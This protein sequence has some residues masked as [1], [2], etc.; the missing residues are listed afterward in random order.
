MSKRD[1][2]QKC[3]LEEITE[4][5]FDSFLSPSLSIKVNE[6]TFA[7]I[8]KHNNVE[9]PETQ[10]H[11]IKFYSIINNNIVF[12]GQYNF[13][14]KIIKKSDFVEIKVENENLII[15]TKDYLIVEKIIINIEGQYSFKNV[16]LKRLSEA[17]FKILNNGKFVSFHNNNLKI[18]HYSESTKDI[19][20]L[21]NRNYDKALERLSNEWEKKDES[22]IEENN[23]EENNSEENE[24]ENSLADIIEIKE[25]NLI[26]ISFS[27]CK[28]DYGIDIDYTKN[29]YLISIIDTKN[30]QIIANLINLIEA[31]KLFYFGNEE[32]FSFGLRK[33][34]KL[35]LKVFQKKLILNENYIQSCYHYY[36][37]NVIPFLNENILVSFGYFRFGYYHNRDE[38]KHWCIFDIKNNRLNELNISNI[39][40]DEYDVSY[41]PFKF[42]DNRILIVFEDSVKLFK[43]NVNELNLNNIE[44]QEFKRNTP[45]LFG[46]FDMFK[47]IFN[48]NGRSRS[49]SKSESKSRNRSRSRS[50]SK[51]KSK[52]K[53]INISKITKKKLKH[54][55]K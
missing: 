17:P 32:L 35:D 20:C 48:P 50:K 18:Y 28:H 54:S 40:D 2:K 10:N 46:F 3:I 43:F 19:E 9:S 24:L 38:H 47:S 39:F 27:N 22:L 12:V 26:I 53:N 31:E 37:Y 30:Y 1:I 21:F 16:I 14:N 51:K 25:K 23:S 4:I 33:F 15:I 29:K 11:F 7:L 49:K 55:K 34:F 52:N 45:R 44:N 8:T 6:K 41:F 13:D 5:K 42:N 36:H